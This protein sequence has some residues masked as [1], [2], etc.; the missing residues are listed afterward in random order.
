MG[1]RQTD[2]HWCDREEREMNERHWCDRE[3]REMNE[4]HLKK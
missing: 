1:D 2:R 4:R 3:E